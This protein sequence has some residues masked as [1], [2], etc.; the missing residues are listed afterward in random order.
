MYYR[1]DDDTDWKVLKRGLWEPILVW[2]T[3]SVPDGSYTIKVVASDAPS[4]SPGTTLTGEAESESFAIDNT[5]PRI[6]VGAPRRA[7]ARTI[8][9]FTVRD[10]QSPVDRVEYSVD[11]ERWKTIYPTD[12]IPDSRVE[13]FELAL[14]GNVGAASVIIRATDALHNVATATGG[15]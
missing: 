3:T 8:L 5:P 15:R 9:P 4:N 6:E 1:R 2:D 7:G 11:A 14:E 13:Q 10:D 12:G